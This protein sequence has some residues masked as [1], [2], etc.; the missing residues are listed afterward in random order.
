LAVCVIRETVLGPG[1]QRFFEILCHFCHKVTVLL[2]L[3]LS[4][5]GVARAEEVR[6]SRSDCRLLGA[7]QDGGADYQPG[8]T[9]DGKSVAPADL[10]PQ[11]DIGSTIV[12]DLKMDVLRRLGV[13]RSSP[14]LDPE[15][16]LGLITVERNRVYFNGQPLDD[17]ET[18]YLSAECL[19]KGAPR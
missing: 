16:H 11:P 18:Q 13:R 7:Y 5:A 9:V 19:E 15:A 1:K 17:A 3:S 6:I 4:L 2:L 14:L 10:A 12:I 8:V